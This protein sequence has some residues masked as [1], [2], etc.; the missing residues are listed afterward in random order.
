M[1]RI[2]TPDELANH[3]D[4]IRDSYSKA[5]S[6]MGG[7][8]PCRV[9]MTSGFFDPL[10]EAHIRYLQEATRYGNIWIS[11]V[12]GD[13]A[14]KRKKGHVLIEQYIRAYVVASLKYVHFAT[15]TDEDSVDNMILCLKPNVFCKGGD[16]TIDNIPEKEKWACRKVK[17][18]I[19]CGVGG[20]TKDNSS[21][22]IVQ[23]F[24]TN[25]NNKKLS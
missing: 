16:R 3:L 22:E 5:S 23:N 6:E 7:P 10:H 24:L 25:Y 21:S 17:C 11:V 2:M 20:K 13:N 19:I 9:V 18:D 15:I 1:N 8:W 14:A 4:N 12:N